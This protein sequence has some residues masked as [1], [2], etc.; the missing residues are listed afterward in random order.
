MPSILEN[1]AAQLVAPDPPAELQ[2]LTRQSPA[3]ASR[4]VL[5]PV[6]V[7]TAVELQPGLWRLRRRPAFPAAVWALP[8][9]ECGVP[10]Y[11]EF[12]DHWFRREGSQLKPF[13][14]IEDYTGSIPWWHFEHLRRP[15]D[16]TEFD[17][18]DCCYA[19]GRR[20]FYRTTE[21]E[22]FC[23]CCYPLR[24]AR[25]IRGEFPVDASGGV[26]V[27]EPSLSNVEFFLRPGKNLDD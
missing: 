18:P 20:L 17:C 15:G 24:E 9:G 27:E 5:A 22:E 26:E 4:P 19:C 11:V 21:G 14:A 3:A 1:L 7:S 10:R 23:A 6:D 12:L 13:W 16:P 25:K 2:Q 8:W